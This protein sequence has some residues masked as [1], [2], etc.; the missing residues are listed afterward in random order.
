MK[1]LLQLF[2]SFTLLGII[3]S[4]Q[5]TFE[6]NFIVVT[7]GNY[8]HFSVNDATQ[9]QLEQ[10]DRF[11]P[12]VGGNLNEV[13]DYANDMDNVEDPAVMEPAT[14]GDMELYGVFDNAFS[15]A[16][17]AYQ[18]GVNVYCWNDQPFVILKYTITNVSGEALDA[19]AGFEVLPIIDGAYGEEKMEYLAEL[20]AFRVYRPEASTNVG[21]KFLSPAMTGLKALEW[22]GGYNDSDENLFEYL[23]YGYIDVEYQSGLDGS[24]IVPSADPMTLGDGETMVVYVAVAVGGDLS[25]I[26]TNL[27]DAETVYNTIIT[28]VEDEFVPLQYSLSQNYP[29][30]FNPTTEIS[31]AIPQRENVS[32]K[33][34]NPIG[35]QVAQLLNKEMEAGSHELSFNA[36]D[37]PSGVYFY[38]IEAGNFTMTKKMMLLK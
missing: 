9:D 38:S 7:L 11:T 17:P 18:I 34:F 2:I 36:S 19:R 29:N 35:Q 20:N 5:V 21:V 33:I 37:L 12:I 8:S 32:I 25:A 24:V 1:K 26:E 14:Y 28:S 4:A 13:I 16:P 6:G 30:P 27:E 3:T 10:I 31:F 15:G 22:Y 23:T